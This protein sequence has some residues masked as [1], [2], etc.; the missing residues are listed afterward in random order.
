MRGEHLLL[1]I[2]RCTRHAAPALRQAQD[3]GCVGACAVV[4]TASDRRFKLPV[5]FPNSAK[6]RLIS[7]FISNNRQ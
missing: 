5:R 1:L 6:S 2:L 3:E 4:A 7:A